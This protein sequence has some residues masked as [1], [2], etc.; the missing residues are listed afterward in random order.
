MPAQ[1]GG[2][3]VA[4]HTVSAS[5]RLTRD[6]AAAGGQQHAATRSVCDPSGSLQEGLLGDSGPL[7]GTQVPALAVRVSDK[8][9][10]QAGRAGAVPHRGGTQSAVV[11][12]LSLC[13]RDVL[14]LPVSAGM[15]VQALGDAVAGAPSMWALGCTGA[16]GDVA[17]LCQQHRP[18]RGHRVGA[19]LVQAVVL[20]KAAPWSRCRFLSPLRGNGRTPGAGYRVQ[21]SAGGSRGQDGWCSEGGHRG[22]GVGQVVCRDTDKKTCNLQ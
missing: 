11:L 14:E 4:C 12:L 3:C 5:W 15:A 10:G 18:K 8:P 7:W 17:D 6:P 19:G 16:R 22:R 2:G 20:N 1:C 9:E 21:V 13:A